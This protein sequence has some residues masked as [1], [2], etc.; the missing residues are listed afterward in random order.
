MAWR[1]PR[2]QFSH[3]KTTLGL[4]IA[5]LIATAIFFIAGMYAVLLSK[6]MPV[7]NHSLLDFLRQDYYYSFLVPLL[8][9]VSILTIYLNWLGMKFFRHNAA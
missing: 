3:P 5:I 4:G 1:N 7:I 9:P 6:F 2:K 8:L